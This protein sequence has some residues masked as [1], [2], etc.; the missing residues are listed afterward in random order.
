MQFV[1]LLISWFD[2]V[3]E[4]VFFGIKGNFPAD[5]TSFANPN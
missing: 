3:I 2:I 5:P 1:S 4:V